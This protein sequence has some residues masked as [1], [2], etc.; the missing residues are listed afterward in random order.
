MIQRT[1][2]FLFRA[3]AV[4]LGQ[5]LDP[6]PSIFTHFG[7]VRLPPFSAT[8]CFRL[9]SRSFSFCLMSFSSYV[10]TPCLLIYPPPCTAPSSPSS[11]PGV[12]LLHGCRLQ[13]PPRGRA[14]LSS[15][16]SALADRSP[17]FILSS[18]SSNVLLATFRHIIHPTPASPRPSCTR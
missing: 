11:R 5:A 15:H 4:R 9:R 3:P 14:R 6:K 17:P 13:T 10:N 12:S 1:R 18:S 7:R 8:G 2:A 16:C